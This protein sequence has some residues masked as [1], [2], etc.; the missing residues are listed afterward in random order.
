[1]SS[2][3]D[4]LRQEHEGTNKPELKIA[5]ADFWPEWSDENFIEPIL[6]KHFYVVTDQK[7]PDVLFHSIFGHSSQGYKCK[8]ILYVA[9]NIRYPYNQSIRDNINIAFGSANYTIT[10]DPT[11]GN[12]FRL[13]LWQVFIM[14]NPKYLDRLINRVNHQSFDRFCSF[15]V[16]NPSNFMRNSMFQQMSQY[17]R[18]HSYG[19]YLTNDN[20]LQ[21]LSKE[22]YWR[23]AKDE[24]FLNNKH[25]FSICYEN[26]SY[27]YYT[28]EKLMDSFLNGSMP[29]YWG[30][31]KVKEDWNTKAFINTIEYGSNIM[32]VI[33]KMDTDYEVFEAKYYQPV[34]TDSQKDKLLSNLENF[35]NW[36]VSIIQ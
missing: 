24:F 25:K 13:P 33:R 3:I 8:K 34:F 28:T 35:E 1:M 11:K 15:V 4:A 16:S 19:R 31:P 26:N 22:K 36:L 2:F 7:N 30:D 23:D 6:K 5:Y 17:K 14:R 21:L 32:S 27:P 10:F 29:I 18:V 20:S 12:N 9:E